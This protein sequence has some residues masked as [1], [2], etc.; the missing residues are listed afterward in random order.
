MEQSRSEIF[1]QARK[2]R[3][4]EK[5]RQ[6]SR[7]AFSGDAPAIQQT[8]PG[9]GAPGAVLIAEAGDVVALLGKS[10]SGARAGKPG[11]YYYYVKLSAVGRI[12]KLH[13]LL[14]IV[15]LLGYRPARNS[16]I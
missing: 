11:T 9:V 4:D 7:G 3:K 1:A 12:Y 5:I 10:G 14:E 16:W 13:V 8:A 15:P 6:S 2:I